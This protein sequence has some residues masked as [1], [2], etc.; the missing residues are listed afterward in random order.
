MTNTAEVIKFPE[1]ESEQEQNQGPEYVKADLDDG[2]YKTA[3]TIGVY[4]CRPYLTASERQVVEVIKLKTYGFN[5]PLDWICNEQISEMTE[6]IA[7][8]H[9]STI[10]NELIRRKILIKSGSKIGINP[11]VSEWIKKADSPKA[12]KK[13]KSKPLDSKIQAFGQPVQESGFDSP[14]ERNHNRKETI[15]KET[16]TKDIRVKSNKKPEK[17]SPEIIKNLFNEKVTNLGKVLKLNP[18]R[19]K[20]INAR[21]DILITMEDWEKYFEKINRSN[22]LTGV[23][24]NWKASFDWVLNDSNSLKILEGNYDNA[25]INITPTSRLNK[26]SSV[27]DHNRQAMDEWLASKQPEIEVNP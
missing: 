23:S 18:T 11:I 21:Q 26:P 8:N 27:S 22:F 2:W 10:K 12:S 6:N 20:L 7:K 9:V 5:K 24:T 15:T 17:I 14:D 19:K 13:P 4:L 3:R 1:K 25:P 16:I